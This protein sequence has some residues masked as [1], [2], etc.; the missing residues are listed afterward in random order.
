M[1]STSNLKGLPQR[2]KNRAI[3]P[4]T[5][6][7]SCHIGSARD[8]VSIN[9]NKRCQQCLIANKLHCQQFR[10]GPYFAAFLQRAAQRRFDRLP[11][12][13]PIIPQLVQVQPD[14]T[15]SLQGLSSSVRH[16]NDPQR[17]MA[18]LMDPSLKP[19]IAFL[20]SENDKANKGDQ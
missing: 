3:N 15:K 5:M 18:S 2:V 17:R 4:T 6:H 13:T 20:D 12:T 10:D 14:I 1:T 11:P 9:N 8:V 19:V 7:I 16:G